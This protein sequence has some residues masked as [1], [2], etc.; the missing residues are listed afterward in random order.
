V[1]TPKTALSALLALWASGL[2]AAPQPVTIMPPPGARFIA[3]QR[4]DI[5][6]EGAGTAPFSATL[7][8]DGVK[9][10]F[11][12]GEPGAE[13]DGITS[14]GFGGFNL[15]GYSSSS[16]GWHDLRATFTDATGTTEAQSR[17]QILPLHRSKRGVRNVILILGDGMGLAHRTAARIVR[18]GVTAGQP[19]GWLEMDRFPGTGLVSTHSL[20]SIVTDS[21]PGMAAY[22]T[23]SHARN[24]QE[25]VYPAHVVSPFFQPRVEYLAEYLH[26][27]KGTALG[28]VTTADVEDATPAANAVHTGDRAAGTGICDQYL[29]EADS[30][31]VRT[32]GTGLAVLMG[33]GRRWFVPAAQKYSSRTPQTD[34]AALPRDLRAGWDLPMVGA[35]DPTRDLLAD[36]QHQGFA[37]VDSWAALQ[38]ALQKQV[39]E[40]LLGLFAWGNM[41]VA[42]DK[43]A[44]RRGTKLPGTATFAVDD[45]RAPDQP[46]LDEMTEVALKVLARRP[47][48]FVL[49]IEGA[50]I[51]KQSHAMD[52]DRVIDEVLEL[53][54][55]VGVARRFAEARTDTLVLVIA[56]HETAGFSLVGA[57]TGGI[58]A[59][60]ALPPDADTAA[61]ARQKVVGVYDGAGFPRYA[62]APDGYP[63]TLDVDGKLLV[64]FGA[65]GNRK[66]TWLT[67]GRPIVDSFLPRPIVA[68]LANEGYAL[69]PDERPDQADG[70]FVRGQTAADAA[71]HTAVDVPLSAYSHSNVWPRFVGVQTNTDV[72]FRL[73]RAALGDDE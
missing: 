32:R 19:D 40:K 7:T 68:E 47:E 5:R 42:L 22:T 16:A 20:N 55:A 9:Q 51:D 67:P 50:H 63:E 36:F 11:S 14:P 23:G 33:G 49:M 8:I 62:I 66:E 1:R 58:A 54:R 25:G 61:P 27:T 69:H 35:V 2:G 31:D 28:L 10:T 24:G 45:A 52:A 15:R 72:F 6:V 38:A 56:D 3:G 37:Y 13:T 53:D 21:A 64:G 65:D 29:D 70:F 34:Y 12:S 4:F 39:P 26:R 48:G 60:R 59:L 18:Y 73:V 44:K 43:L 30:A 57:L 46:M 17:F 41:N 71:A